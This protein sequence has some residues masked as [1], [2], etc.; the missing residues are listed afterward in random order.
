MYINRYLLLIL[1][2]MSVA[3]CMSKANYL[4]DI[5][6]F[7][8][9]TTEKASSYSAEDWSISD[10]IFIDL[11]KVKYAQ[12]SSKLDE[13]EKTKVLELTGKYAALRVKYGVNQ[14]LETIKDFG[15]VVD[16]FTKELNIDSGNVMK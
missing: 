16:S 7:I 15:K 12:Y 4:L 10:S 8:S 6:S 13:T 9:E 1:V 2:A 14:C 3:A 5:E 11:V